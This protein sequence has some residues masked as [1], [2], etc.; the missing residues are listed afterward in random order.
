MTTRFIYIIAYVA[1][2]S[3]WSFFPY[4]LLSYSTITSTFSGNFLIN[5]FI[6]ESQTT[7]LPNV[8]SLT[9]YSWI[10]FVP[11]AYPWIKEFNVIQTS[12]YMLLLFIP[13]IFI[14]I[15]KYY[16]IL[17]LSLIAL[18]AIMFS[19]GYNFPFGFINEHLL[20]LGGPFL[21]L[22]N[23]YY[24]VIQFYVLF[25]S[26]LLSIV[27]YN[28]ISKVSRE[29]KVSK[30]KLNLF[31]NI[32][33]KK[34][35]YEKIIAIFLILVITGIFVYPFATDQ[36]YQD[37]GTNIDE[38]NINNGLLELKNFLHKNYSSPD[39]YTLLIPTSSLDG[40][41]YL[42]YNNNSTFADSRGLISSVDPYPLIWQSNSYLADAIENYLS[43]NDFQNM[44]NVFNYLHIKY[45]IFTKNYS[46]NSY[47]L[48]S[49]NGNYYNFE[50]IYNSLEASFGS[51]MKFGNYYVFTNNYSKPILEL[52]ENPVFVNTTLS[53]YLDFLG[54]INST[55]SKSQSSV[56]YSSIISN[57]VLKNNKINL[58]KASP[59]HNYKLPANN[60]FFLMNNGNIKNYTNL[61]LQ[62][63]NG[64]IN[65]GP[66]CIA[67]LQNG[68][69]YTTN[70]D[71]RNNVLYSD[72]AS[73]IKLNKTIYAPWIFNSLLKISSLP[74][75]DRIDFNIGFNNISINAEFVNVTDGKGNMLLQLSSNFN[76]ENY[77]AWN[78]ISIP[79]NSIGNNI[80]FSIQLNTNDTMDIN[81]NVNSIGF[82][83]STILYYGQNNYKNNPS[84][85]SHNFEL[86]KNENTSYNLQFN[87]GN[88]SSVIFYKFNLY[89]SYPVKYIFIEN[90]SKKPII[91]NATIKTS[92]YGNYYI[93]HINSN[94]KDTYLYFFGYPKGVWNVYINSSNNKLPLFSKNNFS[95]IFVFPIEK[96]TYN[97]KIQYK[98]LVPVSFK[99]SLTE[100]LLLLL[101]FVG[102]SVYDIYKKKRPL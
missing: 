50:S 84:F 79:I 12:A 7:T 19:T 69:T 60:T 4:Y 47:M 88:S 49:V 23:A 55:L 39:Y 90:V 10:Y 82:N 26:V 41:T 9:A 31:K 56:I 57:N 43:S 65:M 78:N 2:S 73:Y 45:I 100:I 71:L 89:K 85:N 5:F 22:T 102:S 95:L 54:S 21:F 83:K 98:S 77:Y 53:N 6:S 25:I 86:I 3:L 27:F 20:L 67:S 17:P 58:I 34:I 11:N 28:L 72:N 51:P 8:L 33:L 15:K 42:T 68:S 87:S 18:L 75:S 30:N 40:A 92:I 36:V 1:I 70:M 61:K 97:L 16:K 80:S 32:N 48:K 66:V 93:S 14:I 76:N 81:V 59:Q 52:I 37:S 96:N 13:T 94:H 44:R 91:M 74:P 38:I 35:N 46:L 101:L 29:K 63:D 64:F 99:I 62:V 24:F